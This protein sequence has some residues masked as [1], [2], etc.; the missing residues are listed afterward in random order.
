M[1]DATADLGQG[2]RKRA[3]LCGAVREQVGDGNDEE[4]KVAQGQRAIRCGV[5]GNVLARER[6]GFSRGKH[7]DRARMRG[8]AGWR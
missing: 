1:R 6:K 5:H 3:Q 4:A 7:K 2:G 8:A